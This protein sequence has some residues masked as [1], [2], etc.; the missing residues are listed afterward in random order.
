MVFVIY[1]KKS[2]LILLGK[3]KMRLFKSFVKTFY[4]TFLILTFI[5]KDLIIQWHNFFFFIRELEFKSL[6][7]IVVTIKL[8]L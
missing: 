1:K 3:K 6:F 8:F 5:V 2:L 4:L 7:S